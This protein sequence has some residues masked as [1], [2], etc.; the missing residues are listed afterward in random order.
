MTNDTNRTMIGLS[1]L[2]PSP[3]NARRTNSTAGIAELSASIN[4]LGLLQNLTV[5][6]APKGKKFEVVAG[7]RRLVALRQLAREGKI[8]SDYPVA[9]N[10]IAAH[11]VEI[12]LAE[13]FQRQHMHPADE[14]RAFREVHEREG[15]QS[16]QQP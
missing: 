6:S 9:V 16:R 14:C 5:R 13:N 7:A 4:S 15:Y 11:S 2:V 3:D 1:R 8:A 10:I 12:S